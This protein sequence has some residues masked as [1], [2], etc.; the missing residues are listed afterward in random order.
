M[1][2]RHEVEPLSLIFGVLFTGVGVAFLVDH[3]E[4]V[5]LR[6]L[7]PA[8]LLGFGVALLAGVL[9]RRGRG[10]TPAAATAG[11]TPAA[12]AGATPADPAEAQAEADVS[13][14]ADP[15]APTV[16]LDRDG[17]QAR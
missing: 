11:A 9:T 15:A 4:L 13:A 10:A 8:L 17:D 6:W 1:M 14:E 7:W 5:R 2:H 3:G 12:T 16:Q